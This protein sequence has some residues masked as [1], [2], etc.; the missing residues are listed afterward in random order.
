MEC[1][2]AP[3]QRTWLENALADLLR[4]SG[5][6]TFVSMPLVE[7]TPRFFP[8]RWEHP[9]EGYDRA[10]RRLMQYAGLSDLEVRVGIYKDAGFESTRQNVVTTHVAGLFLGLKDHCAHFAFNRGVSSNLEDMV[11]VMAHEVAH[12]YRA[13]H[14]LVER[15]HSQKR[16]RRSM[17]RRRSPGKD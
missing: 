17:K 14:G 15:Q 1:L 3:E 12:A 5:M 10:T 16:R 11:G 13:H 2:P 6:H 9:L 8:D 4:Q 7:P